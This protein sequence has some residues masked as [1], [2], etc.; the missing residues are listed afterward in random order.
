MSERKFDMTMQISNS[1]LLKEAPQTNSIKNS[2]ISYKAADTNAFERSPKTDSFGKTDKNKKS[3][4]ILAG[5][6]GAVA[7]V[8][9]G[10]CYSKGKSAD[11]NTKKFIERLKDGWKNLWHK[12]PVNKDDMEVLEKIKTEAENKAKGAEDAAKKLKEESTS[13]L[14]DLSNKA[15]KKCKKEQIAEYVALKYADNPEYAKLY[16]Y[17]ANSRQV[18]KLNMS[19]SEVSAFLDKTFAGMSPEAKDSLLKSESLYKKF[20]EMDVKEFDELVSVVT[21][22]LDADLS[23]NLKSRF[24]LNNGEDNVMNFWQVGK[25]MFSLLPKET[26]KMFK[27]RF[28]P[29]NRNKNMMDCI[30]SENAAIAKK[31]V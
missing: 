15:L 23:Q 9:L 8:I 17:C 22:D 10:L 14:E 27:I 7:L 11:G 30:L 26:D 5:I 3:V 2:E 13:K 12:N 1:M 16:D 6:V 20:K 29:I 24:K 21:K 18:K 19:L 4:G 25:R 28:K 31:K